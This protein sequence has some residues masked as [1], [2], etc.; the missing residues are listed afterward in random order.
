M[1]GDFFRTNNLGQKCKCTRRMDDDSTW[2]SFSSWKISQHEKGWVSAFFTTRR[3]DRIEKRGILVVTGSRLTNAETV[4]L[5]KSSSCIA[6]FDKESEKEREA[7][8]K[9]NDFNFSMGSFGIHP[10]HGAHRGEFFWYTFQCASESVGTQGRSKNGS[11]K[12]P[13]G[14]LLRLYREDSC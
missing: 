10:P 2:S 9:E 6:R 7:S 11:E 13:Y 5:F 3:R 4:V 12:H 14:V 1:P 8:W